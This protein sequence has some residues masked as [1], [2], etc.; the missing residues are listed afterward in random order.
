MEELYKQILEKILK[1]H[2]DTNAVLVHGSSLKRNLENYSDIDINVFISGKPENPIEN[3]IIKYGN[4]LI[5]VNLNFDNYKDAI[6]SVKNEKMIEQ[7]LVNLTTF[8]E[9]KVL[10]DRINLIS[11]LKKEAE[12]RFK[13]FKG[14]QA[15]LLTIKFN[16]LIDFFFK[17]Q[18]AYKKKDI[19]GLFYASRTIASQSARIIQYFNKLKPEQVYNSI[20][21]NYAAVLELKNTPSHFKEDFL[22]CMGLKENLSIPQIYSSANRLVKETIQFLNK[23]KL[24][25]I[26]NKEFFTLLEQANKLLK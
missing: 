5:L 9:T 4:K 16:I 23:Q 26:K 8:K 17:L 21:S 10:Y 22:I 20:L 6:Y 18:R 1:K 3:E 14:K 11:K 15:R 13:G 24:K 19:L 2:K 7:I 25:E 12:T